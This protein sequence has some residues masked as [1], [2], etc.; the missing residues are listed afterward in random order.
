MS[1]SSIFD[2]NI[3]IACRLDLIAVLFIQGNPLLD[4]WACWECSQGCI[5]QLI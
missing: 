1:F 4:V 5:G 2:H 3:A